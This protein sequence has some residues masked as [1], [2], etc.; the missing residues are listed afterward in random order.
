MSDERTPAPG[1]AE[2]AGKRRTKSGRTPV[3]WEELKFFPVGLGLLLAV[4]ALG[5]D[6]PTI[7]LIVTSAFEIG[8]WYAILSFFYAKEHHQPLDYHFIFKSRSMICTVICLI[9]LMLI[10]KLFTV[11][12]AFVVCGFDTRS[13]YSYIFLYPIFESCTL[14]FLS[15]VLRLLNIIK[16][17]MS[18]VFSTICFSGSM[19]TPILYMHYLVTVKIKNLFIIGVL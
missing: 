3:T 15:L 13:D 14:F 2:S 12:I 9:C 19:T 4:P 6:L 11:V 10:M 7:F 16:M 18:Y 1:T 8:M 17:N 5:M